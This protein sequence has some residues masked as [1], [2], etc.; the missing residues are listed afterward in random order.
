MQKVSIVLEQVGIEIV[1]LPV[2]MG[3]TYN[4]SFQGAACPGISAVL[5]FPSRIA[6]GL[7]MVG[8]SVGVKKKNTE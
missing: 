3:W 8:K 6:L 7:I 4:V 5:P 2:L 1:L